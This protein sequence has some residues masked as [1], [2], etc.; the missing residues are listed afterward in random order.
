MRKCDWCPHSRLKN[1]ELKCPYSL[2]LLTESEII[3]MLKNLRGVE[4]K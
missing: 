4:R 1:G 2:C 3:K